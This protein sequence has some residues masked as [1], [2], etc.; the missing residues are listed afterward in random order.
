MPDPSEPASTDHDVTTGEPILSI[1]NLVKRFG[2]LTA[3]DICSKKASG[4]APGF[5]GL[6]SYLGAGIHGG[7]L[8]IYSNRVTLLTDRAEMTEGGREEALRLAEELKAAEQRAALMASKAKAATELAREEATRRRIERKAHEDATARKLAE[9]EAKRLSEEA[10]ALLKEHDFP[11]NIR[12]LRNI[13]ERAVLLTDGV[14]I[15][16]RDSV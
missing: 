8:Q 16:T 12:E 1:R 13:V 6:F 15:E 3:V 7:F 2:G 11:G 4:T 9:F 14:I 10:L 5:V